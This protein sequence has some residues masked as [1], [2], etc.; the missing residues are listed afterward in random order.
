MPKQTSNRKSN[1]T[2][3][4][5]TKR[6]FKKWQVGLVAV[7]VLAIVGGLGT[8]I[9]T[10]QQKKDIQAKAAAFVLRDSDY[11][12]A[13]NDVNHNLNNLRLA[14]CKT[15]AHDV[16]FMGSITDSE[17]N[18]F[19]QY[20]RDRATLT[21]LSAKSSNPVNAADVT[22]RDAYAWSRYG[23]HRFNSV[24]I[25]TSNDFPWVKGRFTIPGINRQSVYIHRNFI[26]Y[27]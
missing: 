25:R 8:F 3:V 19:T 22:A 18:G 10:Q 26:P 23:W 6:S 11:A 1:K 9:Y 20:Q 27:C 2:V 15:G 14:V 7:V 13:K 5:S 16:R 12:Y 21:A 4:R 24:T 17:W